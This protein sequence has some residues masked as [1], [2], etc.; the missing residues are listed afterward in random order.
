MLMIASTT[1][2]IT[3]KDFQVKATGGG[4]ASGDENNVGINTTYIQNITDELSDIIFTYNRSR[5]F[6]TPGEHH[7]RDRIQLRMNQ[8]GLYNVHTEEINGTAQNSNLNKT[9]EILSEGMR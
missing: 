2:L 3:P 1:I 4:S 7:A 6:G 5:S 8:I 9:L